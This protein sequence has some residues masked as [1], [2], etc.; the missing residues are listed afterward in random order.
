MFSIYFPIV[1][2]FALYFDSER[3]RDLVA[4][5]ISLNIVE[6]EGTLFTSNFNKGDTFKIYFPENLTHFTGT[7]TASSKKLEVPIR[8][9]GAAILCS[10]FNQRAAV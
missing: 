9:A 5:R 6:G 10:S 8:Q 1:T 4:E 2:F 7:A 3:F